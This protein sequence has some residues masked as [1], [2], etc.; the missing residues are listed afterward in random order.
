MFQSRILEL[1]TA[2][3]SALAPGWA[4]SLLFTLKSQSFW[5]AHTYIWKNLHWNGF[6]RAL[7]ETTAAAAGTKQNGLLQQPQSSP[8]WDQPRCLSLN[9]AT[10]GMWTQLYKL[11]LFVRSCCSASNEL[12][13]N[14]HWKISLKIG[15]FNKSFPVRAVT[16]HYC[17][18]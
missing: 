6:Q 2:W 11:C 1:G 16:A 15:Q 9:W 8:C 4:P 5:R 3:S 14:S 10:F 13:H 12:L 18:G 7:L 17:V